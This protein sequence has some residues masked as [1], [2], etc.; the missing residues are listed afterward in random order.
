MTVWTLN[1]FVFPLLDGCP[2]IKFFSTFFASQIIKWH[3]I[4]PHIHLLSIIKY[5]SC[6][7]LKSQYTIHGYAL[8]KLYFETF[9]LYFSILL[10][11]K[12]SLFQHHM[13]GLHF[14][15]LI[16]Q[17]VYLMMH[18]RCKEYHIFLHGCSRLFGR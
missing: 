14:L 6:Y 4:Y 15:Y 8:N 16:L 17:E 13:R 7:K 3:T 18:S 10:Q 9:I 12:C 1:F 5:Y 2:C 11:G